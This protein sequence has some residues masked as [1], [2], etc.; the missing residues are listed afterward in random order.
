MP[1]MNVDPIERCGQRRRVKSNRQH[2]LSTMRVLM[3]FSSLLLTP[4]IQKCRVQGGHAK[5]DKELLSV[6][7]KTLVVVWQALVVAASRK[8]RGD[9]SSRVSHVV[10]FVV[11]AAVFALILACRTVQISMPQTLCIH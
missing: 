9:A 1:A 2:Y 3:C 5:N 6:R 10:E 11:A 7:S 8:W 4:S